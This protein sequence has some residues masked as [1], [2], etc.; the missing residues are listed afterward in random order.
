MDN[1]WRRTTKA[2]LR[3]VLIAMA[4]LLFMLFL[5]YIGLTLPWQGIDY[6]DGQVPRS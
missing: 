2:V 3:D 1:R 6:F 4:I 5:L